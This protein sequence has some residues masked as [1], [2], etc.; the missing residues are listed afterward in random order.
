MHVRNLESLGSSVYKLE[1]LEGS[2][3]RGEKVNVDVVAES[4]GWRGWWGLL[5]WLDDSV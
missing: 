4:F 1:D 5:K 2:S 3:R